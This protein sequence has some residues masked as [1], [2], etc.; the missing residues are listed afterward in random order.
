MTL[1]EDPNVLVPLK[2]PNPSLDPDLFFISFDMAKAAVCLIYTWKQM[3]RKSWW[4]SHKVNDQSYKVSVAGHVP[5]KCNF[6]W[7]RIIAKHDAKDSRSTES[8]GRNFNN[9]FS[10]SDHH[11]TFPGGLPIRLCV[12]I[13]ICIN[14][15]KVFGSFDPKHRNTSEIIIGWD[16]SLRNQSCHLLVTNNDTMHVLACLDLTLYVTLI[17]S[18]SKQVNGWFQS[19]LVKLLLLH[20]SF[21]WALSTS[22]WCNNT[23]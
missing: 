9:R 16:P 20:L 21:K 18:C 11:I 12:K 19:A 17:I 22:L 4:A 14:S 23:N 2:W 15:D 7:A 1:V 5:V 8:S 10:S 13:A 6:S 3:E